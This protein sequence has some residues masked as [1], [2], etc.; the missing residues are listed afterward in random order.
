[1]RRGEKEEHD[2]PT[3]YS[4]ADRV[5]GFVGCCCQ[6]DKPGAAREISRWPILAC[7]AENNGK[8]N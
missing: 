6:A 2:A 7:V 1:M 5:F 4:R 3:F 8:L